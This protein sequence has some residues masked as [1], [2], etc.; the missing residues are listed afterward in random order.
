MSAA[1]GI[2]KQAVSA[3]AKT[4]V[5]LAVISKKLFMTMC[6]RNPELFGKIILN[7]ARDLARDLKFLKEYVQETQRKC[8]I[9]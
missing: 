1:I 6:R 9:K 3:L 8:N 4:D 5:K 2:Q 7:V